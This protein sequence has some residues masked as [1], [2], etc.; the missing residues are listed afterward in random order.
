MI[1]EDGKTVW[2]LYILRCGDN[3][4]YTGIT[5][6]VEKRFAVHCSRRG[7]KYT[8]GRGPLKLV[9]REAV[10]SYS[11]ALKRERSVKSMKRNQKEKMILEEDKS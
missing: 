10:G 2:Y 5:T 6:D 7:A 11:E 9:Y 4:L 3:S 8:R 1:M